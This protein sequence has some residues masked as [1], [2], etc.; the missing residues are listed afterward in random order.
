MS[1][2]VIISGG[3]IDFDFALSFLREHRY[4][5]LIAADRGL[6]FLKSAGIRPT[7]I[8]GDFDSAGAETA[9]EYRQ[10]PKIEIRRFRPEKD[11]TDTHIALN[12]ALELGCG[13]IY[14]LGCTGTRVD[15]VIASIR[16]LRFALERQA[17]CRIVDAHNQIRLTDRSLTLKKSEQYGKYV[18]LFALG[19]EVRGLTLEGFRYP[20]SNYSMKGIQ[21][22]GVSNEIEAE[23]ARITF[24][25]GILIVIESKD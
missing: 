18:S 21:S 11:D 7:H 20:L 10:D 3:N 17:D 19:E 9:E 2:A 13:K 25:E 22:L 23:R 8:V 15:H 24:E 14:L 5:Y 12:L 1:T 16:D 6:L 4:Q